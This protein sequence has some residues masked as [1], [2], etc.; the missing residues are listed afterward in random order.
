M[1][2]L[3]TILLTLLMVFT[4]VGCKTKEDTPVTEETTK[5]EE[6]VEESDTE[7]VVGGFVDVEDGTLTDELKEIF[8]KATEGYVGMSLEPI[9]LYQTQVVAG[10]NYK[11]VCS[12]TKTTNPPI[13]GSYFVTVYED[14]EGNCSIIDVETIT[15][16]TGDVEADPVVKE[17]DKTMNYWV[18]FYN[19]DGNELQRSAIK[20]GTVPTYNGGTPQYWDNDY[21][22]KF[23]CWT[24]KQ[25][26]EIK[27]FKPIVGNTYIYAKYEIGGK[28]KPKEKE[29]KPSPVVHVTGISVSSSYVTFGMNSVTV[30]IEPANAK[31]KNF[32][33]SIEDAGDFTYEINGSTVTFSNGGSAGVKQATITSVDGGYTC[34]VSLIFEA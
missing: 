11:F 1:K 16:S 20:Y 27:E 30:T 33:V 29:S 2:K 12:G 4:L 21:W 31:N 6:V 18:V 7:E 15:E 13:T 17:V 32:T 23:V 10:I 26:N 3:L 25:G 24:D 5:Q 22:Y 8:N 28:N 9:E 14:L 34:Y 19:P